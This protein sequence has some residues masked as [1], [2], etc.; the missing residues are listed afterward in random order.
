MLSVC[1]DI[2]LDE[3]CFG[4]FNLLWYV[5]ILLPIILCIFQLSQNAEAEVKLGA[6]AAA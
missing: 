6:A 5:Y 1:S 3:N 4:V 2:E